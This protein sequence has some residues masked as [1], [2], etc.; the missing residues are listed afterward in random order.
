MVGAVIIMRR[1]APHI[2][3]PYRTFG[4]PVVPLIYIAL[5]TLLVLDLA[6]LT[7]QTSGI[8]Y[9]LVLTGLPVYLIWRRGAARHAASQEA[10]T[11]EGIERKS[12]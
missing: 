4:Y 1:K 2:E 7:P 12:D 5:A 3:R 10:E 8:G 11:S 6:Y 9:V